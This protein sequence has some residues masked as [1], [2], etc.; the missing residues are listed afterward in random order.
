M[1]FGPSLPSLGTCPELVGLQLRLSQV[2][3]WEPRS[4]QL[5]GCRGKELYNR[6]AHV[7]R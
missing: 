5:P 4:A 7:Q 2:T 3:S 6:I 1:S